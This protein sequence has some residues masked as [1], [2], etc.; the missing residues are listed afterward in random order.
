MQGLSEQEVIRREGLQ[1][2]MDLNINPFPPQAFD[3]TCNSQELKSQFKADPEKFGTVSIA[4]RVMMKR[5]MGK[6]SFV[7]LQD[8]YGKIQLYINRDVICPAEDKSLYN[9]V[10]KKL[11]DIGDFIGVKGYGFITQTGEISIHVSEYFF[12]SKCLHPLPTV[13]RC[14]C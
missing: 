12:L 7:E 8:A 4:G 1:E 11:T 5:I 9:T 2:L 14:F 3:V 13:K 6:A 10:F